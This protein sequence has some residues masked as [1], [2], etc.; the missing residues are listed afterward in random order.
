M[1]FSNTTAKRLGHC[2]IEMKFQAKG[3]VTDT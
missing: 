2:E 1:S 3:S